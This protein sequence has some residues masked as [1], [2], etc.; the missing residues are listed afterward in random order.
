LISL[1]KKYTLDL[2]FTRFSFGGIVTARAVNS[3]DY[4][5]NIGNNLLFEVQDVKSLRLQIPVPEAY[6]ASVLKNNRA[7]L[8]FLL[9]R[10]LR[11]QL[12]L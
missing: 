11:F 8:A 10:A 9:I 1:P 4:V 7:T 3:G 12:S 6:T 5:N 2:I